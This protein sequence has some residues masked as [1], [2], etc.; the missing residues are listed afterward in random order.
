MGRSL[1]ITKSIIR[2]TC[3]HIGGPGNSERIHSEQLTCL[4]STG[5]YYLEHGL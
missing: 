1:R 3:D 2:L 5:H 4:I